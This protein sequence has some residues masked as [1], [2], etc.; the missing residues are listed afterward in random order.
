MIVYDLTMSVI[1]RC[2][3]GAS[4]NFKI[5]KLCIWDAKISG[6]ILPVKPF[7]HERRTDFIYDN[8][9]NTTNGQ[10]FHVLLTDLL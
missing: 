10:R 2:T 9:K 1:P 6:K 4:K 8:M 5:N 3:Y 7:H